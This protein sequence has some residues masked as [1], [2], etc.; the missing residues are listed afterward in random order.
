MCMSHRYI[1]AQR[2][3]HG[4]SLAPEPPLIFI[5]EMAALIGKSITTIR[6]YAADKRRRHRIP[7]LHKI[8]NSRRLAWRRDVVYTWIFGVVDGAPEPGKVR[9][10][11]PKKQRPAV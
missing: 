10:G 8:Q 1:P 3:V 6:T 5:E 11:R 4:V 2:S 7:P 9:R